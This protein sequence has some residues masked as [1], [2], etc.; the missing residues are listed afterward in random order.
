M[1]SAIMF[2]LQ[3]AI[4]QRPWGGFERLTL[5]E[6]STVKIITVNAGQ[7]LSLQRHEF[8]D[9]FWFVLAGSGTFRVGEKE[10]VVRPSESV[11][12]PRHTKHRASAGQE[13]LIFLEIAFGEFYENDIERFEDD[14]GRA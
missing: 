5:N 10:H 3:H 11:F 12:I 9:E 13:K 1:N 7:S 4:D 6:K 14:Y 8:R 2:L